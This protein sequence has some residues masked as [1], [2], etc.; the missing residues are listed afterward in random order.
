MLIAIEH[1]GG[2]LR[3]LFLIV[4]KMRKWDFFIVTAVI[5]EGMDRASRDAQRL[6]RPHLNRDAIDGP[7]GDPFQSVE[8]FL[9]GIV[10]VRW[11]RKLCPSRDGQLEDRRT[12][13]GFGTCEQ[14]ADLE[15]ADMDDL[16]GRIQPNLR[17][18]LDHCNLPWYIALT[19]SS[20]F[21]T[22]SVVRT[23]SLFLGIPRRL[24]SC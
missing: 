2:C 8:R 11:C 5:G 6:S 24:L 12:A 17:I 3:K 10:T 22:V 20:A 19:R 23:R 7:G 9:I 4:P 13:M 14:E 21:D 15:Y 16:I 1:P 18:V